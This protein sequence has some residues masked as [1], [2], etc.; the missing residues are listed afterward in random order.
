[1]QQAFLGWGQGLSKGSPFVSLFG[2]LTPIPMIHL[3]TNRGTITS[4]WWTRV[5]KLLAQIPV[6]AGETSIAMTQGS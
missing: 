1:V 2:T 4:A 6:T 5:G 3:G